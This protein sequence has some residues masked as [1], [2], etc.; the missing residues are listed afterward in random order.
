MSE[1]LFKGVAPPVS[2]YVHF[3]FC[4]HR[5]HYCDFSVHRTGTPPI[6]DWLECIEREADDRVNQAGWADPIRLETVFVGGGTPSLMGD[7]MGRL[8]RVISRRFVADP[9]G[10]EWTAES[11]PASLDTAVAHSWLEAGVNRLSIGVQSFDDGVLRWLGRL[12]DAAG[13][14]RAVAGARAAGFENLNIDL[15]FGLPTSVERNWDAEVEAVLEAGVTHVSAYGLTAE[16]R[17]PLGRQVASGDV[18]MAGG[19]HYA[20]EYLAAVAALE[21]AGFSHYEV[22]N[23]AIPG[24]ECLHNWHYWDGSPYLGLGPSAHSYLGGTRAWNVFRWEAYRQAL[25]GGV[26]TLEGHESVGAGESRLE[27]LWLALRTNR[28]LS[29]GDPLAREVLADAGDLVDAWSKAGWLRVDESRIRLT[30]EGWL[31]MDELVAALGGR[32][33]ATNKWN[34]LRE[35]DDAAQSNRA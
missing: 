14:R 7:S 18:V 24:R 9:E 2:L 23:F 27:R 22:S 4:V 35:G 12:H 19:D 6:E 16:P 8:A 32:A 3:P 17:T 13:A 28:G 15:I 29:T 25:K 33:T 26:S 11:N 34:R 5:C 21:A 20:A 30:A 31:R 10:P 1:E